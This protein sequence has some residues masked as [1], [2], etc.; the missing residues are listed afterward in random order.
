[1]NLLF[2]NSAS[3]MALTQW[4]NNCPMLRLKTL[5]LYSCAFFYCLRSWFCTGI[6]SQTTAVEFEV[7]FICWV[8]SYIKHCKKLAY[9]AE[10]S[11]EKKAPRIAQRCS[12]TNL[13][14]IKRNS[15]EKRKPKVN[16]T[17]ISMSYS[18]HWN[19]EL[20]SSVVSLNSW[21]EGASLPLVDWPPF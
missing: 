3:I 6:C 10:S 2:S 21:G 1:M 12:D 18:R 11:H 5:E 17:S 19:T 4:I 20:V 13:N 15:P 9:L 7:Y 16:V 14:T 8:C